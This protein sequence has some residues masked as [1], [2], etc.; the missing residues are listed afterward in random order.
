MM[1][2]VIGTVIAALALPGMAGAQL[3]RDPSRLP[4][5]VMPSPIEVARGGWDTRA[6]NQW[7]RALRHCLND[8]RQTKRERRQCADRGMPPRR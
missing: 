3:R 2:M 1:R 4:P 6:Q 7:D 8:R 5:P